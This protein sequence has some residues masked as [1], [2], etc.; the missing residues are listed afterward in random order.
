LESEPHVAR[1]RRRDAHGGWDPA[2]RDCANRRC[3]KEK[4]EEYSIGSALRIAPSAPSLRR[5]EPAR[6]VP[7]VSLLQTDEPAPFSWIA[8]DGTSPFLI[9]CDHAGRRLPRALGTLGLSRAELDTHIAWDVGAAG[10]AERLAGELD[11]FLILQPYSRLVIDCNRPLAEPSSIVRLSE[12]TVVPGNL[13]LS[14]EDAERRADG[15]FHPYHQRI[16]HELDERERRGQTTIL[17]A[18]HSFTPTFMGVARPWHVG[19]LYNRDPR[20]GRILI[21]LLERDRELVVGENE[22]YAVSDQTDYGIVQYGE[23]R[24]IPHVEL[25]IR[26]DLIADDAGQTAWAALLAP[27]FR[28][29][30]AKVCS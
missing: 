24:G 14:A 19:V 26:Q 3:V 12:H 27:L 2:G 10:V 16:R 4:Q 6:I 15:V 7:F 22:P 29:A 13:E 23:R 17:I 25:E 9:T 11:A 1:E 28:E 18:M 8:G 20:L 5:G 30:A 21:E